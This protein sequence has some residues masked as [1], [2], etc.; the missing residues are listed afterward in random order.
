M[1]MTF[2]GSELNPMSRRN[3]AVVNIIIWCT[4]IW[5]L[6]TILSWVGGHTLLHLLMFTP[7]AGQFIFQPWSI[8]T[9]IF[10]H[11][12]FWHLFSNMLWLFFIGAILEDMTGRKHIWR[13]FIGGGLAGATLYFIYWQVLHRPGLTE[14]IPY[15]VGASG[16]VTAVILGTTAMFPRYRVMLFGI[17]PVELFWIAAF[18]VFFDLIGASGPVNQGGYLC[19]LGGAAFGL[20]YMLHIRGT[21]HLPL[22]D[23]LA[24]FFSRLSD[25][26]SQRPMRN[27]RVEINRQAPANRGKSGVSQEEIDR[28]LDKIN[29]SGY[30]S[31]TR[32]ERE[33]LFKAGE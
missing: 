19:H 27:I 7:A 1:A 31:L 22:V 18:R 24:R 10:L 12:D 28:I 26:K 33:K 21:I 6:T 14:T 17:L 4:A 2:L 11:A 30:E 9:Y 16:G 13:L 32:E 3:S 15:M 20:L 29:A 5:L 8:F 23:S 25:R